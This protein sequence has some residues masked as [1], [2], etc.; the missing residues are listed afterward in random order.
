MVQTLALNNSN[1]LAL[2]SSGSLVILSGVNAIVAACKTACQ[3]QLSECVLQQGQGLPNFPLVWTGSPDFGQWQAYLEQVLLN[4]EGVTSVQSLSISA[5]NGT[6]SYIAEIE[7]IY[8]PITLA[9]T[10]TR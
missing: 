3:T 8:S 7:T 4:V 1:D 10:L 9:G 6:L 5:L 2:N